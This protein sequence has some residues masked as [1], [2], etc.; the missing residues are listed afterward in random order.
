MH[1]W[2]NRPRQNKRNDLLFES[3]GYGGKNALD[4]RFY[5]FNR[6]SVPVEDGS[7]QLATF[8]YALKGPALACPLMPL[9]DQYF[10]THSISYKLSTNTKLS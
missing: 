10:C 1:T 2:P 8:T 4:K 3:F 7:Q 6:V 5:H 9:V